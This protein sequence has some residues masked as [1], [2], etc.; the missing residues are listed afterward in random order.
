MVVEDGMVGRSS[1]IRRE[2]WAADKEE[3]IVPDK[4]TKNRPSRSQSTHSSDEAG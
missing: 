4:D 2:T 3:F 1:V